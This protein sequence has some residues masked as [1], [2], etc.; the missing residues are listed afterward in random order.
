MNNDLTLVIGEKI[1]ITNDKMSYYKTNIG[2][3]YSNGQILVGAPLYKGQVLRMRMDDEVD[4]AFYRESGRYSTK[5]RVV[6]FQRKDSVK[7]TM[8]EQLTAPEK[9]QRR[10]FYRLSTRST[11]EL[12]KYEYGAEVALVLKD[13][14]NEAEFIAEARARDISV[15]GVALI[16]KHECK[17]GEKYLMRLRLDGTWERTKPFFI[18]AKVVRS[19][20]ISESGMYDVGMNF[21]GLTRSRREFL[22]KY[23]LGQQQKRI[24]QRKLVEGE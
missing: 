10:D 8:L 2:D 23:I 13:T 11:A 20:Y 6:G 16:T 7:Y 24:L 4:M 21:F 3:M 5:M 22:T 19:D 1:E 14:S 15:T 9:N 17:L 12:Y 18:C